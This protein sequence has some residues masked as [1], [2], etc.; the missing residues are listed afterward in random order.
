MRCP[1]CG[2]ISFDYNQVC[3][4]CNRDISTE[5]EKFNLP[6]FR[7]EPPSLLGF[8][9]GDANESNVNLRVPSGS[10]IDKAPVEEI[11]LN[12]SVVLNHDNMS[13][14]DQDL[15]IS[16]EPESTGEDLFEEE[17]AVKPKSLLSDADFSL[18]EKDE[19]K[20]VIQSELSEEEEISL[21]LEEF[22]LEEPGE[23]P[24]KSEDTEGVHDVVTEGIVSDED[25]LLD[26]LEAMPVD[27]DSGLDEI[28]SEI[29]LDLDDLKVSDIGG[30]EIG[31]DTT[32]QDKELSTTLVESEAGTLE[33]EVES[34]DLSDK[35]EENLPDISELM[36]EDAAA[37]N[38][39]KTMIL[40]DLSIDDLD[41]IG[42]EGP[43]ELGDIAL[44]DSA[45]KGEEELPEI[46]E[47]NLE[48]NFPTDTERTMILDDVSANDSA[49]LEKSFDISDLSL[50]EDYAEDK[51][52]PSSK[53]SFAD[54]G[55]LDLDL[56]AMSLDVEKY[57]KGS[58]SGDDFVLD[59][60]DMDID[61][62]LNE[63]K[64]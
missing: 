9:T 3:P 24:D 13:I 39:E 23:L 12:D 50:D 31:V 36:L 16:F 27:I 8:L 7:P 14:D 48:E 46:E 33:P 30:L 60:E 10:H 6:S 47:L 2:Y 26:S 61:L 52:E 62:D 42:K 19:G 37:G 43:L 25:I 49:E 5:Q 51:K 38:K 4:K 56:D 22:S 54:S 40:D 32:S 34:Y 59:L 20:A 1:K 28:E 44:D 21:D 53:K 17:S 11:D 55:E 63:P 35:V 45:L 15:D 41:S 18:E 29:E 57:Q 64:K 58:D